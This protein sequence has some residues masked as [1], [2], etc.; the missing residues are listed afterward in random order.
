MVDDLKGLPYSS[1]A[2]FISRLNP[3]FLFTAS[4]VST[5]YPR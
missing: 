1:F 2:E 4:Y 5:R 3:L